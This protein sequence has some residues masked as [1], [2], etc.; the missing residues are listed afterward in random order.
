MYLLLV[1][2]AQLILLYWLSRRVIGALYLLLHLLTGSRA[3]SI[4]IVS[5]I[6]FPGTVVHELSHLFTA[7]ILGVHTGKLTLVP[8]S[9]DESEV[10][11][12]SVAIAST[13]PFRRTLIGL[14]PVYVGIAVLAGLSYAL[15]I[16]D[17]HWSDWSNWSAWTRIES[18]LPLLVVYLLFSISNSMFA[19]KEDL[20]GVVPFT[21]T[22]G[23]FAGAAYVAGLRIGVT[24][25]I[26]A[27]IWD[28]ARV[29]VGAIGIV[30]AVNTMTLLLIS[31][32]VD[33]IKRWKRR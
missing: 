30:V 4:S 25:E 22:M 10:Q 26:L 18:H 1:F 9:L 28:V 31:V 24:E 6:F 3:V 17:P 13:D 14:A 12:G 5:A 16:L 27:K 7:E 11:T 21:V 23:I 2:C 33:I 19:S 32:L 15:P 29:L 8:G 20:K